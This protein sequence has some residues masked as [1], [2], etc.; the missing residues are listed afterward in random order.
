[1]VQIALSM[2]PHVGEIEL[3]SAA[4][5]II[6]MQVSSTRARRNDA[7]YTVGL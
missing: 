6:D 4:L 7:M 2:Q 3:D 1:M 5:I